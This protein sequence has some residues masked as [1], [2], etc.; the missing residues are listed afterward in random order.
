MSFCT[1]FPLAT[2]QWMIFCF[3]HTGSALPVF[4]HKCPLLIF[5]KHSYQ[6]S[7]QVKTRTFKQNNSPSGTRGPRRRCGNVRPHFFAGFKGCAWLKR[8]SSTLSR[9]L[10]QSVQTRDLFTWQ[11]APFCNV[12]K[13][14]TT[15]SQTPAPFW[16][17][18]GCSSR[19][20]LVL[21][22]KPCNRSWLGRK[23]SFIN[24]KAYREDHVVHRKCCNLSTIFIAHQQI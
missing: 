16:R 15:H 1:L 20:D 19:K 4:L 8:I 21:F 18:E 5:I 14:K 9:V 11:T 2:W 13:F 17:V 24:R 3:E 12:L 22:M 7:N 10:G 23:P 6:K